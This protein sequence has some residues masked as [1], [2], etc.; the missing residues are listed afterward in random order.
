MNSASSPPTSGFVPGEP[1]DA[2]AADVADELHRLRRRA[3]G[4]YADIYDDPEAMRRLEELEAAAAPPGEAAPSARSFSEP[5]T[6][7]VRGEDAPDERRE[8]PHDTPESPD[9]SAAPAS[10]VPIGIAPR[11]W[12]W[13]PA[14]WIASIL[15]AVGVAAASG[16]AWAFSASAPVTRAPDGAHQFAVLTAAPD[17][18]PSGIFTDVRLRSFG[19]FYG[20]SVLSPLPQKGVPSSRKCLIVVPTANYLSSSADFSAAAVRSDCAAGG[21]RATVQLTIDG[22]SPDALKAVFAQGTALQFVLDGSRVGIFT[23]R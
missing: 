21:F 11:L 20:L 10:A 8:Q 4:P 1:G 6:R 12:R 19:D 17:P 13:V 7:L 9:D 23:D 15:L 3:Y 22:A 2:P 5:I 16:A 14:L 18:A